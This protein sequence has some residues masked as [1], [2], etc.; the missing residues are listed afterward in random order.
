MYLYD[1]K[2]M[3][4]KRSGVNRS[5]S[6]W[7]HKMADHAFGRERDFTVL[8]QVA[9]TSSRCTSSKPML[10][11]ARW[12][13]S[14]IRTV[15]RLDKRWLWPYQAIQEPD[16]PDGQC[17]IYEHTVSDSDVT[18]QDLITVA[19]K[20]YVFW[21]V[22]PC[23][24][25]RRW[26]CLHFQG[27]SNLIYPD[28]GG[29]RIFWKACKVLPDYTVSHRGRDISSVILVRDFC[30]SKQWTTVQHTCSKVCLINQ[31]V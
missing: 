22:T 11:L 25:C 16:A 29:S 23:S 3:L 12:R 18:L 10:V 9:G 2:K 7:H 5:D 1:Q 15:D 14:E 8:C 17:C 27:R 21:I 31:N 13:V 30:F 28:D 6:P 26:W 4:L 20:M 19:V 24:L